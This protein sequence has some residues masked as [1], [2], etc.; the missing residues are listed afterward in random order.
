MPEYNVEGCEIDNT[1]ID[2]LINRVPNF[3]RIVIH[4]R[5]RDATNYIDI[6]PPYAVDHQGQRLTDVIVDTYNREDVKLKN[7]F[8]EDFG[9]YCFITKI[10]ISAF[11]MP[12]LELKARKHRYRG[13]DYPAYYNK[14]FIGYKVKIKS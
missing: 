13:T 4:L 7:T 8:I 12:R 3:D 9:Q 11:G 6:A 2:R 5:R 1:E 14:Y 10:M